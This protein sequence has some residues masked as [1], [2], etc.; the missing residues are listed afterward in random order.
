MK[1]LFATG[2]VTFPY[3]IPQDI[4]KSNGFGFGAL[5]VFMPQDLENEKKGSL[6]EA[7]ANLSLTVCPV[8]YDCRT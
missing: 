4:S 3:L 7:L 8:M 5:T 2:D 6:G 1:L